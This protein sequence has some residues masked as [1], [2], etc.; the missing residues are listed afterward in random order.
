ME[1]CLWM[2]IILIGYCFDTLD[3]TINLLKCGIGVWWCNQAN[4]YVVID[5]VVFFF[6]SVRVG[7]TIVSGN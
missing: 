6:D 4:T 5:L 3:N 2:S 7:E 1:V